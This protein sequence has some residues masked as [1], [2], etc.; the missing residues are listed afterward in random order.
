MNNH[1]N[2][3]DAF[4]GTAVA[5]GFFSAGRSNGHDVVRAGREKKPGMK[6]ENGAQKQSLEEGG[7]GKFK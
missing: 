2:G 7:E 5:T 3:R 4:S 1:G 6:R